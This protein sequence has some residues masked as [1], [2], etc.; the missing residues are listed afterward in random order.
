MRKAYAYVAFDKRHAILLFDDAY[1]GG[2]VSDSNGGEGDGVPRPKD[3]RCRR[4]SI[5][6]S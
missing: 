4:A 3:S 5:S 2:P 6:A 1:D